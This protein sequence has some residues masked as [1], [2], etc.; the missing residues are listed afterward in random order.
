MFREGPS[1]APAKA[2]AGAERFPHNLRRIGQ[3]FERRGGGRMRKEPSSCRRSVD[4]R[5]TQVAVEE[6]PQPVSDEGRRRRPARRDTREGCCQ[7]D[8][9]PQRFFG[10]RRT[11]KGKADPAA[12][13]CGCRVGRRRETAAGNY[14]YGQNATGTEAERG[15][16]FQRRRRGCRRRDENARK[17]LDAWKNCSAAAVVKVGGQSETA[18]CTVPEEAALFRRKPR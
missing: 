6:N 12:G 17:R 1:W 7:I 10:G 15:H 8:V 3:M 16:R 9:G 5:S 18:W 14:Q 2:A 13:K 4:A 11:W